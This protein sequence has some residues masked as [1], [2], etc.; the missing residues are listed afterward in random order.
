MQLI[1]IRDCFLRAFCLLVF[2][3]FHQINV[4][5]LRFGVHTQYCS[6][7]LSGDTFEEFYPA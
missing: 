6:Q 1:E 4:E 2:N 7:R 3:T 5:F